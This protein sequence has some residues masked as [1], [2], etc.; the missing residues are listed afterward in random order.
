MKSF[1]SFVIF[2]FI[3]CSCGSK[4]TIFE[5]TNVSKSQ[6]FNH[7]S[8]SRVYDIKLRFLGELDANAVIEIHG[9]RLEGPD[10]FHLDRGTIDTVYFNEYYSHDVRLVYKPENVEKGD[11]LIE[12]DMK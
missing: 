7:H 10:L 8:K 4:T 12:V 9:G 3:F 1:L 11:L 2:S 6:T 5:L